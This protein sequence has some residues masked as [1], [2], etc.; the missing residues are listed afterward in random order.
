[1]WCHS[2]IPK[3]LSQQTKY[4]QIKIK[5]VGDAVEARTDW[6]GGKGAGAPVTE[7]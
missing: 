6:W 7:L 5:K 1:M 4:K 2:H 3:D